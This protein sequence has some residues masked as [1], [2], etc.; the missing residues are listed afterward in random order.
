LGIFK[1][2]VRLDIFQDVAPGSPIFS[3][4]D[5]T[6]FG[7]IH[8]SIKKPLPRGKASPFAKGRT[9]ISPSS[10]IDFEIKFSNMDYEKHQPYGNE[11]LCFKSTRKFSPAKAGKEISNY[12]N[13][14][15]FFMLL[16]WVVKYH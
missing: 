4:S 5:F 1:A 13:R 12:W 2:G 10:V 3:Y 8:S 16:R 9:M 6:R 15:P 11:G 7:V 14:F